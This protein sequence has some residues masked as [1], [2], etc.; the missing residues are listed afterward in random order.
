MLFHIYKRFKRI[1]EI[2]YIY[3]WH[4]FKNSLRKRHLILFFKRIYRNHLNMRLLVYYILFLKFFWEY[5]LEQ[6]NKYLINRRHYEILR[7][8]KIFLLSLDIISMHKFI[9]C[10]FY[11][12]KI[13]RVNNV[14][15][16]FMRALTLFII[17][18]NRFLLSF[19]EKVH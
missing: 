14:F 5:S 17:Q 8:F 15:L 18:L 3:F 6:I 13:L 1:F 16:F 9:L 12:K 11:L 19:F 2:F 7:L 4:H 10:F